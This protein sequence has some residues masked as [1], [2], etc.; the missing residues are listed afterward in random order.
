[1]PTRRMLKIVAERRMFR[2]AVYDPV[3]FT[4]KSSG[5]RSRISGGNRSWTLLAPSFATSTTAVGAGVATAT[6]NQSRTER[7]NPPNAAISSQKA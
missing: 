6:T 1:M 4:R 7:A 3:I 5:K 2:I